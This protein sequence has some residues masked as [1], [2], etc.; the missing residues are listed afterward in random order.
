MRLVITDAAALLLYLVSIVFNTICMFDTMTPFHKIIFES[1]FSA[2]ECRATCLMLWRC[3]ANFWVC[4]DFPGSAI[5]LSAPH[6]ST[7]GVRQGYL[8]CATYTLQSVY[9]FLGALLP[10]ACPRRFT[11]AGHNTFLSFCMLMV[12]PCLSRHQ[13]CNR[14]DGSQL[15]CDE[16][17]KSLSVNMSKTQVVNVSC[18][19]RTHSLASSRQCR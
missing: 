9:W 8:I 7:M 13:G 16:Y 4:V 10:V 2:M 19:S 1:I 17:L 15:F 3:Y 12:W 14:L 6:D 18:R 5:I 11:V